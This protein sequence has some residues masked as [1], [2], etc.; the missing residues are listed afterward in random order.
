MAHE[1]RHIRERVG[2]LADGY[3][4]LPRV[5]TDGLCRVSNRAD[6]TRRGQRPGASRTGF[7]RCSGRRLRGE[8]ARL[9]PPNASGTDA[10]D[11]RVQ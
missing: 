8:S 1:R 2:L 3:D 6:D 7:R 11:A 10:A 5:T 9:P 4:W